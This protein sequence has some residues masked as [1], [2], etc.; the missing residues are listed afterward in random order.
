MRREHAEAKRPGSVGASF[1]TTRRRCRLAKLPL[2]QHEPERVR[3]YWRCAEAKSPTRN[4]DGLVFP[5]NPSHE[6]ESE[7]QLEP[8]EG[9]F[10]CRLEVF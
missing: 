8:R 10:D 3:C 6:E 2:A 4:S 1:V 7:G 9:G 5:R